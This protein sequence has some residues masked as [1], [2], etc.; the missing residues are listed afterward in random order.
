MAGEQVI[1]G[2]AI[3]LSPVASTSSTHRD[4]DRDR[5]LKGAGMGRDDKHIYEVRGESPPDD[6]EHQFQGKYI[7]AAE[8]ATAVLPDSA[9]DSPYPEVRAVV[10][11]TDD[12]TLPV[13]T[14]RAWFLGI[15]AVVIGAGV[16]QFFSMRYPSVTITSLVVQLLAYPLGNALAHILPLVT[17][18]LGPNLGGR[19]TLNPDR[20]F[21]IKEHTLVT[22]MS[23]ISYTAAW[24]TDIIQAQVAFY[25]Q[26]A[27]YGYQILL[28]LTCQL[29][30][31]GV[32]GLVSDVLVKPASMVWPSTLA[33]VALFQTLHDRSNTI[34]NGWRITRFKYFLI[35]FAASFV[36]YWFPGYLF[37]ALSYFTWICWAAPNNVV[38][39]QLFGQVQ[40]L[41]FFPVTFDWSQ[42]AYNLS[43]ILYPFN[44]QVNT[45]L[46]WFIFFAVLPPIL[47]YTNTFQ[48]A[49]LPMSSATVYDNTGAEYD[50]TRIMRNGAFA[51][52]LY[53]A[54]S[55]PFLPVTYAIAYSTGFAV[56]AAA[57]VYVY[58]NYGSLI[59]GAL[60][61]RGGLDVHARL[62]ERY[63]S[64]PKWWYAVILLAV[65][66]ATIGTMEGY[67]IGWPV[68]AITLALGMVVFFVLPIGVVYAITNQNTNQM[69]VLGQI[70]SGYSL[71]GRPIVA[72]TFK[73]YAY[74]G[75]SQAVSFS[76][77]MKL[78]MYMKLPKITVFWA[79]L[80]ACVVGAL[81]QVGILI[82][83]LENVEGICT[84]D[85]ADGFTCPQGRTNYAAS[86]IWGAVGPQRLYSPG[87]IYSGLMHMFWIGALAPLI[88]WLLLKKFPTNRI[89]KNLNWVVI[90]GGTGNYPPATGVNYTSWFVVGAF[91][92][93]YLK[94]RRS[95][96]WQ[97]YAYVT[98]AALDAGLAIAGI[99][100]FFA[101]GYS[102]VGGLEWWGNSVWQETADARGTAWLRM[103]E[104]GYFGPDMWK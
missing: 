72:L 10:P 54:Y 100:I 78:G 49:Y 101:L 55:P 41:G 90:F 83:M 57:P 52:D 53:E 58:L 56:L 65:Y 63:R 16:N 12:P 27:P 66:G 51:Q 38:V 34:A 13:N 93:Y 4:R 21:N 80:V 70:I 87:K 81:V 92:N 77:D 79:Q 30:G 14:F 31:L 43:P 98:S 46:G 39:N 68:W 19:W 32:A 61:G 26:P 97:K 2:Q 45:I 11:P 23:N 76:Q 94:R 102:G 103:P 89:L 1:E 62:M 84:L 5:K 75:I 104:K 67:A 3:E 85:Q 33:N 8:D 64:V 74:T 7:N 24:A 88:T 50:A 37:T 29:F 69:T 59:W 96:W 71:P 40:G 35:V 15:I 17:F 18:D 91:F 42:I 60:R 28:V 48:S 86:V 9:D 99:V 44:A 25:N 36:W 22:I 6:P 20:K 47:Y 95:A 82:F 73:F